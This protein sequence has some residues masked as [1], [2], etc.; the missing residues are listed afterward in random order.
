[1]PITKEKVPSLKHHRSEC[2]VCYEKNVKY[3]DITECYH[4][5]C[6]DCMSKIITPFCPICREPLPIENKYDPNQEVREVLEG[7]AD[8]YIEELIEVRFD[9]NQAVAEFM[10]V[11]EIF[12]ISMQG[13]IDYLKLRQRLGSRFNINIYVNALLIG[14]FE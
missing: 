5:V 3:S 7:I 1:M 4:F 12:Q 10:Q 6:S 2:C 13:Y 8:A 9:R 11:R 14:I